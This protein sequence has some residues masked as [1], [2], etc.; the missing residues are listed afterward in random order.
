MGNSR[1]YAAFALKGPGKKNKKLTSRDMGKNGD[2][3]QRLQ[4]SSTQVILVQYWQ[5]IDQSVVDLME[6]LAVAKS[7]AVGR[8]IYFGIIDG[9][10]SARLIQAYPN[11]FK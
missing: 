8:P 4:T 7:Y 6:Q 11:A 5:E 2:Q 3:I 1:Y 10:D 9:E